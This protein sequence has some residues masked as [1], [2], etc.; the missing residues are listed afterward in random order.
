[1]T[2]FIDN[3][4]FY[5]ISKHIFMLKNHFMLRFKIYMQV[6]LMFLRYMISMQY[7]LHL[8]P[9]SYKLYES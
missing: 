4:I 1:M 2:N 5:S 9:F 7:S 6:K 8:R 3:N